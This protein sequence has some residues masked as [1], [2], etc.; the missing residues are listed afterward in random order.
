[1]SLQPRPV[2]FAVCVLLS[3]PRR[4]PSF[5]PTLAS[6]LALQ[7]P[8]LPW[9]VWKVHPPLSLHTHGIPRCVSPAASSVHFVCCSPRVPCLPGAPEHVSDDELPLPSLHVSPP[10]C[11][12]LFCAQAFLAFA[13]PPSLLLFVLALPH[14]LTTV[15]DALYGIV[16]TDSLLL[17]S[18]G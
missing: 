8:V 18:I 12:C 5:L 3:L 11:C 7:I 14:R 13:P 17:L 15:V 10:S 16:I 6:P 1:M 4:L 2:F 9:I